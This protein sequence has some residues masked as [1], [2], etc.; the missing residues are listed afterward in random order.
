[1]GESVRYKLAQVEVFDMTSTTSF[2]GEVSRYCETIRAMDI[3]SYVVRKRTAKVETADHGRDRQP[4]KACHR[5]PKEV[6]K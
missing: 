6:L 4:R 2:P 3:D 5:T 1:M